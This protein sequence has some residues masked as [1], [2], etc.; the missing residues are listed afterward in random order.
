MQINSH[1]GQHEKKQ[2]VMYEVCISTG[3]QKGFDFQL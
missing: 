1:E 3:N 2:E